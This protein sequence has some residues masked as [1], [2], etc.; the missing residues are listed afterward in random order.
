MDF[1][2]KPIE[3]ETLLRAVKD[4]FK[5]HD[6][7]IEERGKKNFSSLEKFFPFLAHEIRNPLHAIGGALAI[8]QRRSNLKD[9][10]LAKSI[11]IIQEEI[12]H[13]NEFVQDCLDFVR[14]PLK[15]RF[16]EVDINEV[17]SVI[18][19][20]M[21]HAFEDLSGKIKVNTETDPNLPKIYANYEE[22]IQALLNIMKNSFEAMGGKGELIIRTSV[23]SDFHPRHIEITFV[24]N[25]SGIKKENMENLFKPFFTTKHRGTGLGLAICHRIIVERHHGKI[26]IESEEGKMTKVRVEF[27]VS[28][29]LGHFKEKER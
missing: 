28:Q 8:I 17:I 29:P 24:D 9:E 15:S 13:L 1:L 3:R 14:P 20:I 10:F 22:V 2:S 23:N 6:A 5:I 16:N 25:G 27:P 26:H 4:A 21:S 12:E 7:Q 19:N 11:K 18:I